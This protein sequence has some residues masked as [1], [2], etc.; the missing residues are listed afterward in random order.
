[1]RLDLESLRSP[2]SRPRCA[3]EGRPRH[4]RYEVINQNE[5]A[6]FRALAQQCEELGKSMGASIESAV[7][8]EP[9]VF[10]IE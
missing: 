4:L 2:N 10:V 5:R 1:M 9:V 3:D 6:R 8:I 7:P